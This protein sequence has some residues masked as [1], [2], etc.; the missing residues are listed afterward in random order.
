MADGAQ[1]NDDTPTLSGQGE[2]GD[3]V[4]IY[5]GEEKLGEVTIDDNGSWSFTPEPPLG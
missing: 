3:T 4:T 1:T 5:D 2:P